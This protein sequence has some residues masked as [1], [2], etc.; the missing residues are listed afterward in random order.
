MATY[1]STATQDALGVT[2]RRDA[3]WIEPVLTLLAFAVFAIYGFWAALQ[4][5]HFE[6]GPYLSPFY[7]PNLRAMFPEAMSWIQ[8]SPSLLILWI[9]LGFRA[10]CYFYRR[11]YY[12]AI[13]WDPPACS[14]GEPTNRKY[15]GERSFPF[16]WQN[17]HRY[18]WYLA[19]ALTIFHWFHAVAAFNFNGHFGVGVGTVIIWL[20]TILLTM[21]V[22]TCHSFRHMLGGKLNCFS[23]SCTT[24]TMHKAWS[25]QSIF[26]EKHHI[27]AWASLFTIGFCD[28]YIRLVSMGV[29]T[30]LRLL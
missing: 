19:F 17:I 13:F 30:D 8:F 11:A 9:P 23:C 15:T 3:W 10:T 27:Y 12:R 14:V 28:L 2:E 5:E 24:K 22:L 6:W 16:V 7:S 4:G 21:Y 25:I 26:N 29:I 20:D 18:F 1:A